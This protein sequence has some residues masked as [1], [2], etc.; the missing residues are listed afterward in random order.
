MSG[1]FQKIVISPSP[2]SATPITSPAT[3]AAPRPAGEGRRGGRRAASAGAGRDTRWSGRLGGVQALLE[4]GQ[5]GAEVGGV[6]RRHGGDVGER[7]L[8]RAA[9]LLGQ[10]SAAVRRSTSRCRS[11]TD[12]RRAPMGVT[13][14]RLGREAPGPS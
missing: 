12:V 10:T 14:R 6:G 2:I 1:S 7:A 8:G 9:A 13:G 11:A 3:A 4:V 5:A